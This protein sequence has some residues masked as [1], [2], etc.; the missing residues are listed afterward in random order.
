MASTLLP[1]RVRSFGG[2]DEDHERRLRHLPAFQ[3][4]LVISSMVR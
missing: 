1:D 2:G 3:S 4:L